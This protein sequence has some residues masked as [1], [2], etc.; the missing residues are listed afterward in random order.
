MCFQTPVDARS[1]ARQAVSFSTTWDVGIG[2]EVFVVG[3]H[4]DLGNWTATGAVKLFWTSGNVWTGTIAVQAG[5]MLE[6]KFIKRTNAPGV[7][8][9]AANIEWT[10]GDNLSNNLAAE[11]AAPYTGKTFYYHSGWTSAAA[12]YRIGTNWFDASMTR[13]GAGRNA[14]EYRYKVAGIG[15]EGEALEFIP[16]GW[17]GGVE[18]WDHAPFGGYG[19]SNYFTALDVFFLQDGNIYNYWPPTNPSASRVLTT[20]IVSSWAPTIPSR[21]VR[22]YLP[23]GYDQNTWKKYPV[24]YFHDGQNVFQP[25]G[26]FGCWNAELSANKEISQGR[27]RETILVAVDTTSERNR[28]LCP[29]GDNEGDGPGTGNLYANFLVHNVRPTI[30]T[31][32]R[33][34]NDRANTMTAGSSMGGLASAYLGLG[35]N[36]FGSIGAFSPAFLVAS[37]FMGRINTNNTK[38]IRIYMD[39]GTLELDATLWPDTWIAY[40]Y[41]L[42]DKYAVNDDLLMKVGCGQT[43]NEAAWAER[44][45][46]AYHFLLNVRGEENQ[47][48]RVGY[49]PSISNAVAGITNQSFS[50]RIQT[51]EQQAYFMERGTNLTGN[52]WMPINAFTESVPWSVRTMID[53][54]FPVGDS[55][56]YRIRVE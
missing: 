51:L 30:D 35:T 29:P 23:R 37:N 55:M 17:S 25:G 45:P 46:G 36:V 3:N 38:G 15:E 10:P 9:D 26:A 50:F 4:P 5:T 44:L 48:A 22:I 2:N 14:G 20:N 33:T 19:D 31:H 11:P 53:T 27:M 12:V 32:Y 56:F 40:N 21:D 43:H 16:H 39:D 49:P 1:P 24:L 18:Y 6:Y 47:L 28:E 52:D 7:Y 8:C 54:N 41:F 34:L 13:D 42:A